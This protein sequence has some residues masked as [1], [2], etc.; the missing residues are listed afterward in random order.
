VARLADRAVG[1]PV[2]LTHLTRDLRQLRAAGARQAAD[3]ASLAPAVL[4]VLD[5]EIRAE[6]TPGDYQMHSMWNDGVETIA[7][8]ASP[9][10]ATTP[11]G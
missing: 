9:W 2:I 3:I 10:S 6:R 7:L 4:R 8:I 1:T 11:T 5:G